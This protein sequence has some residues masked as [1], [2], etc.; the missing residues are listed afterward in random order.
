MP[1]ILKKKEYHIENMV[2]DPLVVFKGNLLF[3]SRYSFLGYTLSRRDDIISIIYILI[4]LVNG[5]KL[6]LKV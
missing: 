1:E 6:P 2:G 3:S 5:G 4:F